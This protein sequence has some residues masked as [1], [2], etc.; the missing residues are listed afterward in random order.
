MV[1]A[2][3]KAYDDIN[4]KN[5]GRSFKDG[6]AFCGIIH[7][8]RP[9]LIA[10][11]AS[12]AEMSPAERCELAFSVAEEKLGISRL[13]D[14]EDVVDGAKPD[15]KSIATYMTEFY[16][17]FAQGLQDD[18]YIQSIIKAIAVTRRHDELISEYAS[19]ANDIQSFTESSKKEYEDQ[20]STDVVLQQLMDIFAWRRDEKPQMAAKLVHAEGALSSLRSSCKANNRP[21]HVPATTVEDLKS[22]WQDMEN[23]EVAAESQLREKYQKYQ[24]ADFAAAG[25]TSRADKFDRWVSEWNATFDAADFGTG[26]V[27]AEICLNGYE[28]FESQLPK[29]A[30][31]VD[32]IEELA[33]ICAEC[34]SHSASAGIPERAAA[35]REALTALESAGEA[36]KAALG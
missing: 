32:R 31:S 34:P 16:T 9:D 30:N 1:P 2:V 33:G 25:A 13:L 5:F 18:Q 8:Y 12:L 3:D 28:I 19:A 10:D 27:G 15:E 14:V 6:L 21:E 29:Y 20:D 11:P 26:V 17:L 7:R 35:S 22:G 4:I 36:Y 24:A 23:W